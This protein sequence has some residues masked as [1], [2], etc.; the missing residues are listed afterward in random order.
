MKSGG[1]AVPHKKVILS[2]GDNPK[3]ST[4]YGMRLG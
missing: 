3:T 2:M 1:D 4:G